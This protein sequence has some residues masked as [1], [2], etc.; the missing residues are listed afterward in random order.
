[1]DPDQMLLGIISSLRI[2]PENA[3]ESKNN[4]RMTLKHFS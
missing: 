4:L 1:L 3:N 2:F